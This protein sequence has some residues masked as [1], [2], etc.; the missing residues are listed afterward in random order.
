MLKGLD[1]ERGLHLSRTTGIFRS[2]H[3][4]RQIGQ[5]RTDLIAPVVARHPGLPGFLL[6]EAE[7]LAS[8]LPA[9]FDHEGYARRHLEAA[10]GGVPYQLS[11]GGVFPAPEPAVMFNTRWKAF[12]PLFQH[13]RPG[14]EGVFSCVP[15]VG[16]MVFR[17]WSG[18]DDRFYDPDLHGPATTRFGLRIR[19]KRYVWEQL[20]VWAWQK[21]HALGDPLGQ[22]G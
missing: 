3:S 22:A 16:Y 2:P 15:G 20:A 12:K 21:A 9:S 8:L 10:L 18:R 5:C 1:R 17:P 4:A 14:T 19:G 6:H 13:W 7:V 11:W